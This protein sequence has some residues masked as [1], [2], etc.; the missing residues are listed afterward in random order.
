MMD[1]ELT[2]K[3]PHLC[4]GVATSN[5]HA[6]EGN[7]CEHLKTHN[8][9]DSHVRK[10]IPEHHAQLFHMQ[11]DREAPRGELLSSLICVEEG[12]IIRTY[13]ENLKSPGEAGNGNFSI[14]SDDFR[15]LDA[16]TCEW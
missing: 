16:I 7:G 2:G 4:K 9:Q 14:R 8:F 5:I 13:E 15:R 3:S 6:P 12:D 1:A 11:G 10:N